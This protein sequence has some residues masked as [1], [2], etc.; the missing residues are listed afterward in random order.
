VTRVWVAQTRGIERSTY[1]EILILDNH[2]RPMIVVELRYPRGGIGHFSR[3]IIFT[4]WAAGARGESTLTL[5][6]QAENNHLI[7]TEFGRRFRHY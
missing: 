5:E 2:S 1:T 6:R 4:G 7:G 3:I